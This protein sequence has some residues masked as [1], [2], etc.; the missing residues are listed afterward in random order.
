MGWGVSGVW[1]WC[2]MSGVWCGMSGVWCEWGG[3]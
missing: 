3:V 2:G 1:V